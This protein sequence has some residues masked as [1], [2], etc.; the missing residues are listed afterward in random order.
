MMLIK[1]VS[2]LYPFIY[3]FVISQMVVNVKEQFIHMF[4]CFL[5]TSVV[6]RLGLYNR[7]FPLYLTT[8][9][10]CETDYPYQLEIIR[11]ST[12]ISVVLHLTSF[13]AVKPMSLV[14]ILRLPSCK[15]YL[16]HMRIVHRI[17]I[18]LLARFTILDQ[19]NHK[20]Q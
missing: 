2:N 14:I 15:M 19:Y 17:F 13:H 11:W 5:C 7:G 16:F 1:E 9:H 3:L 18:S 20:L 8:A 10:P 12:L 4:R 6:R